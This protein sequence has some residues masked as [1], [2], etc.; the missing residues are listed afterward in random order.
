MKEI[1]K[2]APVASPNFTILTSKK[3]NLNR[4]LDMFKIKLNKQQSYL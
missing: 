4:V 3:A 2:S 1:R